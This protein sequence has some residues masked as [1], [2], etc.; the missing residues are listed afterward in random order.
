M[1]DGG[2][3]LDVG[4][5]ERFGGGIVEGFDVGLDVAADAL[6]RGDEAVKKALSYLSLFSLLVRLSQVA[7]RCH[8]RVKGASQ[9]M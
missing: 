1:V 7:V 2:Q 9:R 5:E 8:F 4:L 6:K 3:L